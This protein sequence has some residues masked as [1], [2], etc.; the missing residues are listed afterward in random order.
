MR[1]REL[2][3]F[4]VKNKFI[5]AATSEKSFLYLLGCTTEC[6]ADI[7]LIQWRMNKQLLRELLELIFDSLLRI[8]SL[9]KADIE[10]IT[11]FCFEKEGKAFYLAKP[12]K[13]AS[14]ESD[15][16]NNFFRPCLKF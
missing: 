6:P 2:Y 9:K 13:I 12:K 16:L 5:S 1:G 14:I 10:R 4:L 15:L 11:P 8:G 7:K 3:A